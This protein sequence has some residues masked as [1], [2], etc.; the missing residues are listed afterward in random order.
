MILSTNNVADW[1]Y[2]RQLKQ[3][4]TNKDVIYENTT[5]INHDYR[6]GDKITT[7]TKSEY[8]YKTPFKVPY[9][10]FHTWTNKTVILQTGAVTKI[11]NTCNIKPYTTPIVEG[12]N[13]PQEV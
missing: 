7:K 11:R 6:V 3:A 4:Q 9:E 1:R 10:N 2:I 12:N 5:I 8:K 13:T